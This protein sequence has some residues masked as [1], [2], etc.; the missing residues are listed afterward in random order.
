MINGG[1]CEKIPFEAI[2]LHELIHA[3][4][5][6]VQHAQHE[7]TD[8]LGARSWGKL[9]PTREKIKEVAELFHKHATT[10][11]QEIKL[12]NPKW[13][14]EKG[15]TKEYWLSDTEMV[16]HLATVSLAVENKVDKKLLIGPAVELYEMHKEHPGLFA[17]CFD[18]LDEMK[19]IPNDGLHDD[20]HP[21]IQPQPLPLHKRP[22]NN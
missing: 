11:L 10:L 13:G 22:K 19:N 20:V 3:I 5:A 17:D 12:H 1:L 2:L 4:H 15:Y 14:E 6:G 21:E 8:I 7:M 9:T 18:V 16:P